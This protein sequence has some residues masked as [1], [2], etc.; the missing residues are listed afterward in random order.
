MSGHF[1]KVSIFSVAFALLAFGCVRFHEAS[2][3][4]CRRP[5]ERCASVVAARARVNVFLMHGGNP[6]HS[7]GMFEL[8]HAI[9]EA[10]FSK[11]YTAQRFD[12]AWF[13]KEIHRLYREE[14]TNRFLL[15]GHGAAAVEQYRL[16]MKLQ[17]DGI[18]IDGLVVLDPLGL[19]YE[20]ACNPNFP[21][22]VIR[23]HEWTGSIGTISA[24]TIEVAN[25]GRWSL[26][27]HPTTIATI[28]EMLHASARLV[29]VVE[30]PIDCVPP[31]LDPKPVP[32]PNSPR[33]MPATP[34]QWEG[35]LCPN[36]RQK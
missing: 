12:R 24:E 18:P 3:E 14:S 19:W 16:A 31:P 5:V 6:T 10:G 17:E 21:I 32:R 33:E 2:Y 36:S 7:S 35:L 9:I 29:P 20:E 26:L 11:T 23:S 28:V 27:R 34:S 8:E 13:R 25:I 4:D 22:R 1:A 30:L 15:V